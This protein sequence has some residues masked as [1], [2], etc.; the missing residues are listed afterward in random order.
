M[1]V[2]PGCQVLIKDDL[3]LFVCGLCAD[4]VLST[5]WQVNSKLLLSDSSF[6][7]LC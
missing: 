5:N 7:L 2:E 4:V 3:E 1:L 6:S